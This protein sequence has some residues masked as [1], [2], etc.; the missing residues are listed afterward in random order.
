MLQMIEQRMRMAAVDIDLGEHRKCHV[1]LALAERLDLFGVARL[2]PAELVAGKAEHRNP[3]G[4]NSRC[5]CS[6]PL[7]CGV[8][9][10]A[11]AVL[12]IRRT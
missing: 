5:N 1:I 10:Q 7:Y 6:S 4:A 2:L 8:N 12:T 3:R 11:L 9:P